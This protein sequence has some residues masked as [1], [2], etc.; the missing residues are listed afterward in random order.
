VLFGSYILSV[1]YTIETKKGKYSSMMG[2]GSSAEKIGRAQ[3]EEQKLERRT[4]QLQ[5]PLQRIS[6]AHREKWVAQIRDSWKHTRKWIG[7]FNTAE[8]AARAYELYVSGNYRYPELS[9]ISIHLMPP[10]SFLLPDHS[11][12][13][14]P[15][16][17]GPKFC[18]GSPPRTTPPFSALQFPPSVPL[19]FNGTH[20]QAE[21]ALHVAA[22]MLDN[23]NN[24]GSRKHGLY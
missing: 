6:L 15:T 24:D 23:N 16:P 19:Q 9:S 8:E 4:R 18:H 20:G 17:V 2:E 1:Y 13:P 21:Q 12:S 14:S 7:A 5:I 3:T 11:H 22:T 10:S